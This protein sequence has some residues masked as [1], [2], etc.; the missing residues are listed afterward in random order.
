MKYQIHI[1]IDKRIKTLQDLQ[2]K[3]TQS[4]KSAPKGALRISSC[5]RATQYYHRQSGEKSGGKY[6]R[7]KNKELAYRLAQKDYEEKV[8]HAIGRELNQLQIIKTSMEQ[9]EESRFEVVRQDLT[10]HRQA[11]IT[12]FWQSDEEFAAAWQAEEYDKKGFQEGY[13]DYYTNRGERVRSKSEILIANQLNY[14]G[15]PYHYERPL[16]LSGYGVIHPDF[17]ILSASKRKEYYLEHFGMMDE[18]EYAAR[19]I[20]RI[21]RY[22]ACGIFPGEQLVLTYETSEQPL[23]IRLLERV[24]T[25]YIAQ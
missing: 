3:V 4:L 10:P 6:I 7:R 2:A 16:K 23:S 12:P 21:K 8:L 25:F 9:I 22:E 14:M 15:I 11:M 17:T 18:A 24:L 19:A 20:E 5:A 13:P 1:E